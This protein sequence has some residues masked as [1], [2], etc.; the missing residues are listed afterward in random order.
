MVSEGSFI[1]IS[2]PSLREDGRP[3]TGLQGR[4][5]VEHVSLFIHRHGKDRFP[6]KVEIPV[7]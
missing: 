2:A 5:Q 3:H 1:E 7:N 4:A 6:K